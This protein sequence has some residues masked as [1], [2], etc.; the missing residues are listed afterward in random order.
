MPFSVLLEVGLQPCGWLAAFIGSALHSESDLSFR[1]LDGTATQPLE[2]FPDAGP[3]TVR[4]RNT[5]VSKAGPTNIPGDDF[6]LGTQARP[7]TPGPPSW[8]LAALTAWPWA[9]V[10]RSTVRCSF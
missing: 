1:N 9:V 4:V 2:I 3:P 6:P 7:A 10:R 5:N 8:C